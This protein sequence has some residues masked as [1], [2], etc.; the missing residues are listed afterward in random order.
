MWRSAKGDMKDW[1]QFD[2]AAPQTLSAICIWNY[3]DTWHTN[4]GVR[5]M[6]ISTWTQESGWQKLRADQLVD[7]AEGGD[8]YDEP[9]IVKLDAPTTAQ[10]IRFDALTNFGDPDYTGLGEVQFFTSVVPRAASS[11]PGLI[12]QH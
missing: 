6:D 9:T 8:G 4:Q 1:L 11:P 3:N 7:Q 2:F 12:S 10:K 5:K